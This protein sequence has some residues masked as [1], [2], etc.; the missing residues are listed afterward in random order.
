[1]NK[2][3]P[4]AMAAA[5]AALGA[6]AAET[7]ETETAELPPVVVEASRLGKT[8]NEIPAA[9]QV[10]THDE[11][12]ASGARDVVDLLEKRA[13]SLNVIRTGAGNPALAQVAM[14]GY[15]ENGFGRTLVM[16]DGQRLNFAD[17]S[18]PLLPQID[19]GAVQNVE[20]LR[21]SQNVLHGDAASA[22][23][24]NIT[25]EP[26]DYDL[27]GRVE[28]HAGSW[29]TFGARTSL[30]G[31]DQEAKVKYWANG[32]WEHSDG[33]R[34]H[35]GWQTWNAAG[36][37][38]KE[39]ENGS[40]LRVSALYSD[41]DYDLPGYLSPGEWRHHRRRSNTHSDWYRRSTWG[42]NTTLEAV[43]NEEN[44]LRL[45]LTF[46]RSEMK[47]RSVFAGSY[48]DYDPS[49]GYA[50]ATVWYADDYRLHYDLYTFEATPQWI[51]TT[52][53][54]GLENEL[55]AGAAYRY[56]RLHGDSSDDM[57][58]RPDFWG[59]SMETLSRFEFNRQSMGVFAQDTLNLTDTLSIEGGGR[60]QRTWD[61][62]T[63]LVSPRR[64]S[65]TYAADA[66]LL[67]APVEDLKSY[68]RFSR[69]FRNPFL[70]ENPFRNYAAQ[71]VLSPETGWSV[72]V[73]A[74]Y[75]F[76]DEFSAF[77]DLFVSRTKHEILYDKFVWNNN[78]NAPDDIVREGFSVGAAWEREKVAGA[79]L[80]YTFVDAE[81]DGGA[82]DGKDVPM[83][84]ESTAVAS[85]R[86]WIWDECFLFGGGRFLS[87]RRP[88]SDF[89]NESRQMPSCTL[90]HVGVQYIPEASWLEGFRF[91]LV[92]D[93]LF[94][95]RYA[96]CATRSSNSR[97]AVYYPGAGRSF[98]FTVSYEF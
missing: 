42:L 57:R 93:N 90:F 82:Y 74:D 66:A 40:F 51:N 69:F 18:A 73:G 55:I 54:G 92:V 89:S 84:A 83:V 3:L 9:V 23:A 64:V 20:I 98:T 14:P 5:V 1:M 91:C 11:I 7:N 72:N 87:P 86:V 22:G 85:G 35:N 76:L 88:F 78:V 32:G 33:F 28:L 34:D 49:N 94:D 26:Q 96:D 53:L 27:H 48:T 70:D 4:A 21:G 30:R 15:G 17:M 80:A 52:S 37:V 10:V 97:D 6:H 36:G 29:D 50:P 43:L 63:T 61:E 39:W 71:K 68:V 79:R 95:R 31:G 58:Y 60:Y 19:L 47:T 75:E 24:I 67:F 8:Q 41:A 62:N 2:L 65:D 56:D 25:T 81:F 38:K 12:A 45:D 44:R 59:S 77:A 13:N 16:V 46:S